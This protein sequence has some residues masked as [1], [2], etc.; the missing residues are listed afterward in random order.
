MRHTIICGIP[1]VYANPKKQN[2]EI[3]RKFDEVPL[4]CSA[5]KQPEFEMIE[6]QI[7]KED[8][9]SH[10]QKSSIK[11]EFS[12]ALKFGTRSSVQIEKIND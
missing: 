7:S 5:F 11:S 4:G 6:E 12:E 1:C 2:I 8:E 9:E 3:G 10:L